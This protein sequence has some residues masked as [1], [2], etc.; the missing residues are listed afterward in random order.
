MRTGNA[1]VGTKIP[2]LHSLLIHRKRKFL[3]LFVDCALMAGF[4]GIPRKRKFLESAEHI[5]EQNCQLNQEFLKLPAFSC[6]RSSLSIVL[7]LD[8]RSEDLRNL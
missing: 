6:K 8:R 4:L 1:T 7:Y 3:A 5:F 2:V